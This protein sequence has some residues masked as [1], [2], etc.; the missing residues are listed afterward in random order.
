MRGPHHRTVR[1]SLRN[2]ARKLRRD[3]TDVERV[4]WRLLRDRR[5]AGYKFRRQAPFGNFILDFVC[6]DRRLVVEADGGQHADS[7]GDR[8]R[9]AFLR[10]NGFAVIRYWNHE[11]LENAEGVVFDLLH[12]LDAPTPHPATGPDQSGPVATLSHKGRG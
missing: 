1:S 2:N 5:L 4:L 10:R 8:E 7:Q 6:D 3:M 12:R 11:I 9:D